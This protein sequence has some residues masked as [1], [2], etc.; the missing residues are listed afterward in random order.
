M[1]LGTS[2]H[3]VSKKM[4]DKTALIEGELRLSYSELWN[5]IELLAA[6]LLKI[7][8]KEDDRVAILLP[9][10]KEFIYSFYALARI[11]AISIPLNQ[12]A[13]SY[14][15]KWIFEDSA[16]TVVITT[17]LLYKNKVASIS[18]PDM[19]VIL[20]D[21]AGINEKGIHS[22][23]RLLKLD[24]ENKILPK[25]NTSNNRIATINYTYRG[26]GKPLGAMLTHGNYHYGAMN[27][28]RHTEIMTKQMVLLVIPMS[29][30]FTL[31]SCVIVSL[32]RGA[33]IVIMKSFIPSHIFKT[34]KEHRIDFMVAVPTVYVSLLRN[35]DKKRYDISSLKYGITGGSYMPSYLHERIKNEM[36][37]ELFQGYGLTETMPITCNP[38]SKNKPE[39]LGIV[40]RNFKVKMVDERGR[41]V[42][43]GEK[44]EI[45]VK[46]RSVMRGYY[47]RNG[48]NEKFLK[49]GWF[50]T[51][52]YGWMDKEGYVY[53]AGLKKE[54]VKIGG[55][56]VDLN[57]VKDTLESFKGVKSV[58]LDILE[59]ELW[60]HRI[61][62]EVKVAPQKKI[63]EKIIRSFCSERLASYK[64]PKGISII[65]E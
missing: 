7:G 43:C 46:G 27:Y 37:I 48:E 5:N 2:L 41:V 64:I 1:N 33:T 25:F 35:Y 23:D 57:G 32:L 31:I 28:M 34:I 65:Q 20:I 26:L 11:N 24:S 62:A 30:I 53:F 19:P 14:E 63:T 13:T 22:L 56:N 10:C 50:Y 8:I 29:H 55:Y 40:G 51:G 36:G 54:I 45:I 44:G 39:S 59:D 61:N 47:N 12:Y 4:R 17:S 16:P 15:L 6:A 60:G 42:P 3:W 9:N 49:D 18:R 58:K 21:N 38:R 52:D